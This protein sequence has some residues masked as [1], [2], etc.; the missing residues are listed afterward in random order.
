[1]THGV[2]GADPDIRDQR[3]DATTP[4]GWARSFEHDGLVALLEPVTTPGPAASAG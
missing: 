1:V 3:F 2:A 4:L